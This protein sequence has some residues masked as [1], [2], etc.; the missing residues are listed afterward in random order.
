MRRKTKISLEKSEAPTKKPDSLRGFDEEIVE[1][2]GLCYNDKGVQ[3]LKKV[4]EE[5]RNRGIQSAYKCQ[6]MDQLIDQRAR[7][8]AL[9]LVLRM[10]ED[11]YKY[12]VEQ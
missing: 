12:Y 2:L 7:I 5:T 8:E 3:V 10:I 4:M 11:S 6:D 1:Q 9:G